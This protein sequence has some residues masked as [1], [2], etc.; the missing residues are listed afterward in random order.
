MPLE[1][2]ASRLCSVMAEWYI[3]LLPVLLQK[4]GIC[5]RCPAPLLA[6]CQAAWRARSQSSSVAPADR[7]RRNPFGKRHCPGELSDIKY[8]LCGKAVAIKRDSDDK[9]IRESFDRSGASANC[10]D[11]S[12]V[13]RCGEVCDGE[14]RGN[15][16]L[17]RKNHVGKE[18]KNG[19]I[20]L[21]GRQRTRCKECGGSAIC[22]HGRVRYQCK[23]CGG[24]AI[25]QPAWIRG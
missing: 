8:A 2:C 6:T 3:G 9:E 15:S 17:R 11:N 20:C 10:S 12:I 22:S 23:E 14:E 19:R 21:H 24:S 16:G 7:R 13:Q 5:M 1:S 18:R 4:S 25:C